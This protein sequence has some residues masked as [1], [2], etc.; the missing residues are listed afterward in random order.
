MTTIGAGQTAAL[1]IRESQYNEYDR[2][3]SQEQLD[4]CRDL[5]LALGYTVTDEATLLDSGPNSTLMRPGITKLIGLIAAGQAAA[6]VVYTL[7]RLGRTDSEGL[8]ALLRELRRREIPVYIAHTPKGYHYDVATGKL[9]HDPEEIHA[10]NR[11]EWREPEFIVIPR[12]NEQDDLI[13]DRLTL[14]NVRKQGG[15]GPIN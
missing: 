11:E 6:V 2:T 1:Y 13:A 3:P 14:G 12:E 10:A 5:A 7:N 8:E 4:A 9:L 15:D